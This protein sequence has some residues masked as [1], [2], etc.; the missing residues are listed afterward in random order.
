MREPNRVPFGVDVALRGDYGVGG[1]ADTLSNFSR[2]RPGGAPP[3]YQTAE[4]QVQPGL[5]AQRYLCTGNSL[6]RS[7]T[8]LGRWRPSLHSKGDFI[9]GAFRHGF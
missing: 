7:V 6:E 5:L 1:V 3:S 8:R 2:P 4:P 9:R